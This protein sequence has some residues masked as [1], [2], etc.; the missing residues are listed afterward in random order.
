MAAKKKQKM[1]T[2]IRVTPDKDPVV[3]TIPNNLE[4]LQAEVGGYIE[5]GLGFPGF[6]V[7]C[8]EEGRQKQLPPSIEV[9]DGRGNVVQYVGT[10][11][12]A[13]AHGRGGYT[14]VTKELCDSLG[15]GLKFPEEARAG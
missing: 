1:L 8:N 3:V 7:I 10:V 12:M 11:L 14:S 4:T 9:T 13:K 2:C 5:L 15:I 6:T